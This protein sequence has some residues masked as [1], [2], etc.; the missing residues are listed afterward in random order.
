MAARELALRAV[1]ESDAALIA[2]VLDGE[3]ECYSTLVRRHQNDL[4][5]HA[6]GMGLDHDAAEDLVQDAFVKAYTSLEECR[7]RD[8]FRAW[9]CR[10]LRNRCL[11]YL[12]D[13]RRRVVPLDELQDGPDAPAAHTTREELR[14][15]LADAFARLPDALREAFL[16]KHQAGYSYDEMAE[17]A[18]ASVSAMKMRVHRA[19]EALRSLLIDEGVTGT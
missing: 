6:R 15:P 19:R 1:A 3:R 10:I 11:D 16:L 2:R 14:G 7:D 17:I 13:I 5:R 12:R 18:G 8:R 4:Y 9:L